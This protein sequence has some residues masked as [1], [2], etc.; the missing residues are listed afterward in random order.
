MV[1]RDVLNGSIH[2]IL[3]SFMDVG[4]IWHHSRGFMEG[5]KFLQEELPATSISGRDNAEFGR[6]S[7]SRTGE[8]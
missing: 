5:E 1:S 7:N 2:L 4:A 3:S 6:R 8:S